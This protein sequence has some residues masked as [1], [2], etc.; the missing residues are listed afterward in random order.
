VKAGPRD[1]PVPGRPCVESAV[2]AKPIVLLATDF[3][4]PA[5]YAQAF[6]VELV[7]RHGFDAALHVIHCIP[8]NELER[9]EAERQ[10]PLAVPPGLDDVVASR[11]VVRALAPEL[12]IVETAQQLGARLI[13][14]G[15]HGRT[16]LAHVLIGSVAERVVRLAQCPVLTVRSPDHMPAR[17]A[18]VEG[19]AMVSIRTILC[20][21]DF[22]DCSRA[23]LEHA[24][25]LARRFEASL[26]VAHVVE[27]VLYPVAYGLPPVAPVAFEE[28]ARSSAVKVM[29]PIVDGLARRGVKARALVDAGNAAS[30]ICDLAKE[31]RA[32]LIVLATHGYTGM[33]H[34]L[35][36]S[37]A[38][39]VVRL[40]PCAVLAVKSPAAGGAAAGRAAATGS[41]TAAGGGTAPGS[42]VKA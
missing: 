4:A 28:G 17:P 40:A 32:D 41:G 31:E 37:T 2:A 26:I 16:N 35:L 22:S 42:G 14:M 10:L 7:R 20:P 25:E 18:G 8:L 29:D 34:L 19:A 9:A 1:A 38:E 6:A 15:T 39:K 23:A 30:R 3:S 5:A 24:E 36:G 33:K 21:I 27:P 12:G 11:R 13:V